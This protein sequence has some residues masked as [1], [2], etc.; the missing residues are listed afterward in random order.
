MRLLLT[1]SLSLLVCIFLIFS[2]EIQSFCW[3][4]L[5]P[6]ISSH[7]VFTASLMCIHWLLMYTISSSSYSSCRTLNIFANAT[8]YYSAVL[9]SFRKSTLYITFRFSCSTPFPLSLSFSLLQGGDQKQRQRLS[10]HA[11]LVAIF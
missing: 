6:I 2:T 1:A 3:G 5:L 4:F 10:S 11:R 9:G 8:L 7:V